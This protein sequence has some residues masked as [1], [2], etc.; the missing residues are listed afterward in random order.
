MGAPGKGLIPVYQHQEM[1][2][3][4]SSRAEQPSAGSCNLLVLK[5]CRGCKL[6]RA[7]QLPASLLS[8]AETAGGMPQQPETGPLVTENHNFSAFGFK[9]SIWIKS[10]SL[11][12]KKSLSYGQCGLENFCWCKTC[13][14]DLVFAIFVSTVVG[15]TSS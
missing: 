1:A 3:W 8:G 10:L 14:D 6:F 7:S 4:V 9:N 2:P 15:V 11:D 5:A 12:F 13:Y